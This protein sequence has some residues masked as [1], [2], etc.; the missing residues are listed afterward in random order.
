[1][2]IVFSLVMR[3]HFLRIYSVEL[4]WT[5]WNYFVARRSGMVDFQIRTGMTDPVDAGNNANSNE[6]SQYG[7]RG[8]E[9]NREDGSGPATEIAW[10][11]VTDV[12]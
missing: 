11:D 6:R 12:A 10:S 5:S 4:Y 3:N 8:E 7:H 2:F 1:M 9:L